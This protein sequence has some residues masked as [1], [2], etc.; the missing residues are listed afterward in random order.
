[1]AWAEGG[2]FDLILKQTEI[3]QPFLKPLQFWLHS[4]T[5]PFIGIMKLYVSH[6]PKF[7]AQ[8]SLTCVISFKCR[9]EN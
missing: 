2:G 4:T 5:G 7:D 8:R 1:M 3:T 6:S 9:W